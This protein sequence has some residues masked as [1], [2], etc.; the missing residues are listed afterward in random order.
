MFDLGD[1]IFPL[2]I[3]INTSSA[4]LGNLGTASNIDFTI[5]GNGVNFAK[6]L[7]GSCHPH[8]LMLGETT[9]E[10]ITPLGSIARGV[11]KEF[12]KIKHHSDLIQAFSLNPFM[13]DPQ[14]L[15]GAMEAY[16]ITLSRVKK[17]ERMLENR[18]GI[19]H[20]PTNQGPLA[21]LT[22]AD[23]GFT[24]LAPSLYAKGTIIDL[25]VDNLPKD[26]RIKL[27]LMGLTRVAMEVVWAYKEQDG[28]LHEVRLIQLNQSEIIAVRAIIQG[29]LKE[30]IQ[31]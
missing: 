15:V 30:E 27:Q 10:L 23:Y 17:Q 6:R 22:V 11:D 20:I 29:F 4:Y 24:V 3:G 13:D 1:L 26:D 9:K 25:L 14:L 12:I 21:L 28:C 31:A 7:E 18:L 2:R 16:R 8:M 5:I 19:F